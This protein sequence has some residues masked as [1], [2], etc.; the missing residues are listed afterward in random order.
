MH[1][2]I[3]ACS[4]DTGLFLSLQRPSLLPQLPMSASTPVFKLCILCERRE[5]D[6]LLLLYFKIALVQFCSW[7][8][9]FTNWQ[10]V[11]AYP[12]SD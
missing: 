12:A 9:N 5:N 11:C 6:I 10:A 2:L 1:V 8:Q 7:V 3:A 4:L